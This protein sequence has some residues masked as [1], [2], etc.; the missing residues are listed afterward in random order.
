MN[1][2]Q[3]PASPLRVLHVLNGADLYGANR[4][5]LRFLMTV[6]RSRFLP[7]VVLPE[8][9]PLKKLIEAQ[10]IEIIVIPR[11]SIITRP[12]FCSWR[13]FPFFLNYTFSVLS[14]HRLIKQKD[15]HLVHTNTGVIVS[16]ALAAKLAGVPHVWHIREWFQEFHSIW[17]IYSWFITKSSSKVVAVS[18]AVAEQFNSR[19]HVVVVHDG[20]SR[21]EFQVPKE[22]L[23]TEF[24]ARYGLAGHFVV[25]CVGRIK[26]VRKGQ[27][28]L[29]QATALLKQRGLSI[30]TLI[31]GAPFR[32]NEEHLERMRRM[33]FELGIEDRVVFTGELKD[34]RGAYAAMDVFALTSAQPEPFGGV[35]ME[36]MAMGLPVI[37][38]NIGGSLD[39]VE[40]DVTGVF[41]PPG[42][43]AALADAIEKLMSNSE[44]RQRMGEAGVKRIHSHFSLAEATNKIEKLFEEVVANGPSKF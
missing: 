2:S 30:K 3:A 41:V 32:G 44:L 40:N 1:E 39:Q 28:F 19:N 26:L 36:A 18:N 9:G 6:D 43:A 21:E 8:D 17:P 31:I 29:V 16:S 24:Q 38:T 27:E 37:A 35:V 25:G 7:V 23:R 20:F 42:D 11:L 22:N 5:L 12:V 14:L 10:D 4:C 13:I 33:V 15:I 34:A